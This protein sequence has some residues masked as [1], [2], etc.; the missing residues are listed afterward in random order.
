[1][2]FVLTYT[3]GWTNLVSTKQ[4]AIDTFFE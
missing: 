2:K 1:V 4:V 3:L